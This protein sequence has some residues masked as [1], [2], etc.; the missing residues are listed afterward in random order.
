MKITIIPND[1]LVLID[2][3]DERLDLSYLPKDIHA[4]HWD[5]KFLVTSNGL[6]K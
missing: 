5:D 3:K 4:I 6:L 1:N 2:D